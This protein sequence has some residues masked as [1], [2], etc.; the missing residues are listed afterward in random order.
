MNDLLLRNVS[1]HNY[2]NEKPLLQGVFPMGRIL[3]FSL[4][5]DLGK[6]LT[7]RS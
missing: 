2:S 4:F 6:Q 7:K 1:W 3:N 5:R